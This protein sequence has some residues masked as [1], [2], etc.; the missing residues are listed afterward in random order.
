M[1]EWIDLVY[2]VFHGDSPI[3][4]VVASVGVVV[5]LLGLR[6]AIIAEN[7]KAIGRFVAPYLGTVLTAGTT[8]VVL[9]IM[10]VV[11]GPNGTNVQEEGATYA[12][13]A[14]T[15]ADRKRSSPSAAPVAPSEPAARASAHEAPHTGTS[16]HA[17]ASFPVD[18]A[19]AVNGAA[20]PEVV[21]PDAGPPDETPTAAVPVST[22][23]SFV[24]GTNPLA[25]CELM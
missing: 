8:A 18:H 19:E 14:P 9:V 25:K 20:M 11:P 1:T 7:L 23:P 2:K 3:M 17:E 15:S 10:G 6:W 5:G 13:T 12:G 4:G 22:C 24:Q 21:V 16:L